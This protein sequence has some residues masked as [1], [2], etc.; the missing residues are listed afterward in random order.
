[1]I[2]AFSAVSTQ[3]EMIMKRELLG[4]HMWH[5]SDFRGAYV[6]FMII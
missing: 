6:M 4:Q 2:R 5:T 3:K 1:M